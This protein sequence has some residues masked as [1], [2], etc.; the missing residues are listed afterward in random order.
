MGTMYTMTQDFYRGKLLDAGLEV[1]VPNEEDRETI[2]NVIFN[3][4]CKGTAKEK[5]RKSYEAIAK[6]LEE[7]GADCLI[8][9][10]T[11][12]G[13]LLH[14]GNTPLPVMDT[15]LIH[16]RVAVDRAFK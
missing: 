13:M 16:C 14:E 8:L 4:L 15:T 2:H 5:S 11:E 12:I 9:G 1:V 10:C 7:A 6:R 3:E